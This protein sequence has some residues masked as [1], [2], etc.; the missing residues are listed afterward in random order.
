MHQVRKGAAHLSAHPAAGQRDAAPDSSGDGR[1][2]L[3]GRPREHAACSDATTH[4]SA[5]LDELDGA[6]ALPQ[7][8]LATHHRDHLIVAL[9]LDRVHKCKER[10]AVRLAEE[11]H[12]RRW[13]R[14]EEA[15][16]AV[17]GRVGLVRDD[18]VETR[19]GSMLVVSRC[20]QTRPCTPMLMNRQNVSSRGMPKMEPTSYNACCRVQRLPVGPI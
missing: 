19:R 12:A 17:T 2:G 11:Q 18:Q 4:Q 14:T 16:K 10:H 6:Q 8:V 15:K 3:L 13:D 9:H 1:G 5:L 7:S 20:T